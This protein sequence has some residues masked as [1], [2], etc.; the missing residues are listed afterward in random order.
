MIT[1]VFLIEDTTGFLLESS[2]ISLDARG[3][4]QSDLFSGNL[5]FPQMQKKLKYQEVSPGIC[6][7][8][9]PLTHHTLISM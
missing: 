9:S 8:F 3:G 6:L 7:I 5:K 1:C 2:L 4:S